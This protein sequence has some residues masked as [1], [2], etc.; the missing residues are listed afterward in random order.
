[1][2]LD[3][4]VAIVTGAGSGIGR[5]SAI[6]FAAE[7]AKVVVADVR[8]AKAQET[9]DLIGKD[10]VATEVDVSDA[11]QVEAMVQS[12]VDVFGGLDV[13]FNNAATTRL[14]TAV[15]LSAQDW[16]TIWN[17]NV[18]SVFFGAKYA[19]PVMAA[20]GGGS[21]VSTASVSGL[22]A[23]GGQ[24]AYAATKAAVINLTRA[25]AVDHAAQGIRAN[26][27][28]PGMTATPS[29]L[30]ALKADDRLREIGSAAPPLRR[31]AD[32]AEMAAAAVWLASS[33]SSYVTGETLV[34]D[35]GLT[36]QTHFS[37][38]A[39]QPRS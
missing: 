33:E 34:V 37:Q 15:E 18:S 38:I 17:T 27:L 25:L 31:L 32:P 16:D 26:C 1:M 14:G 23:D 21:I 29:L 11:V 12:A 5:A 30:Y 4:K 6:R 36:S 35:G 7:G 19:V 8:L 20:R 24:V 39:S 2:L 22:A 9:V 3:G 13:L 10:A 28:C